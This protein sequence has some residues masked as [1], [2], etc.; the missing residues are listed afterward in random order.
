MLATLPIVAFLAASAD[1]TGSLY[2]FQKSEEISTADATE[3]L[4]EA[5]SAGLV[6]TNVEDR[7]GK[8]VLTATLSRRAVRKINKARRAENAA[9][10]IET[11]MDALAE[12]RPQ[13]VGDLVKST[14]MARQDV[15]DACK[16]AVESGDLFKFN[17]TNSNFHVFYNTDSENT[18][19][20]EPVVEEEPE[21]EAAPVEETEVE[22]S[23]DDAAPEATEEDA[24][25]EE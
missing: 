19:F 15:I 4:C 21:A 18:V 13:R 16:A 3:A 10:N 20:P 11:V 1:F 14:G 12:S 6:E 7:S 2:G 24:S 22:A 8:R 25:S 9:A 17:T 5:C 23:A